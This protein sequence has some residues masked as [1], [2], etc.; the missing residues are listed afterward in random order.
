MCPDLGTL[1]AY[2]DGELSVE[3]RQQLEKHLQSCHLC[4]E[5]F[6]ELGDN[7]FFTQQLITNYGQEMNKANFDRK[8]AWQKIV[9][10]QVKQINSAKLEKRKGVFQ[11]F[12]KYRKWAAV[13]AGVAVLCGSM[14]FSQVRS[15][16]A[17]FLNIFRVEKLQTVTLTAEDLSEVKNKLDNKGTIKLKDFG[18]VKIANDYNSTEITLEKAQGEADFDLKFFAEN[19]VDPANISL[20]KESG[21]RIDFTLNVD[22]VN[23]LIESLGGKTLLPKELDQKTFSIVINEAYVMD[24]NSDEKGN[25][26]YFNYVQTKSPEVLVPEGTNVEALRTALLALPFLPENIRQQLAGIKDWQHTLPI[27][28]FEGNTKEV[29]VDGT[30]GVYL[31]RNSKWGQLFWQ[32]DGVLN[33]LSGNLNMDEALELANGLEK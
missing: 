27:P 30:Q 18:K 28:N 2:L 15:A 26:N 31:G 11:M 24:Y 8:A 14:S 33:I 3:E 32:K 12:N 22:K 17:S 25:R 20:R 13:A 23:K 7:A 19:K 21:N 9:S 1:Q 6:Q 4:R 5:H 10:S 16:A 29:Q